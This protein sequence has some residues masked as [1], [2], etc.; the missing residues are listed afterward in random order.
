MNKDDKKAFLLAGAMIVQLCKRG[1][2]RFDVEDLKQA[3]KQ[4]DRLEVSIEHGVL[5]V[6]YRE[7][8]TDVHR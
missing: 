1:P 5:T 8:G 6:R 2:L 7:E 3:V 4:F